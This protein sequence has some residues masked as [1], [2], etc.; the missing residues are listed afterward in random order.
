M[1]GL[2]STNFSEAIA[3]QIRSQRR[4]LAE[5][6][7][8]RLVVL[9]P[10]EVIEIFPSDQLLD[11]IPTL[12][13]ELAE[14]LRVP[15]D[16]AIPANAAVVT[17]AMELGQ[18]RHGQRASVHQLLREYQLLGGI[19][20]AFVQEETSRL[21]LE[22]SPLEA[23]AL[24][25]RL[26]MAVG[27]LQQTTV[28]TFVATYTETIARQTDRLESFNRLVSHELRQP[29]TALQAAVSLIAMR[30]TTEEPVPARTI[31]LLE[32]NVSRLVELTRQLEGVS[33]LRED[34]DNAQIQRA[35]LS[36][37]AGDVARQLRE[38]ADARGVTLQID[39]ELG[40]VSI[41]VARAELVLMNLMSNAIKYSDPAKAERI[42]AVERVEPSSATV[43]IQVRDNGIGIDDVHRK[44]VFE[45]FFRGDPQRDSGP[46][47]GGLGL[48]LSIVR[49]CIDALGGSI[50]LSSEPG[51]GTTFTLRLPP[52][53]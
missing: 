4:A 11:H 1:S 38:M 43:V 20:A 14:Y 39:P 28:D 26:Q 47:S 46:G 16:E 37:V 3:A 25:T 48:G 49:E 10:V 12:I 52:A 9:L 5:R 53:S 13:G 18:L 7:L 22:P 33:R 15:E 40:A 6:W 21:G 30:R 35:D 45:R 44:L 32:R 27:V 51:A 34:D 24:L 17:K 42:V 50:D 36:S 23:M 8:D 2:T 41:D 19:L 29:L 31:A